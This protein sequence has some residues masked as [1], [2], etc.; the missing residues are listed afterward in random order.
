MREISNETLQVA[1][2][3]ALQVQQH[4]E[5]VR[6]TANTLRQAGRISEAQREQVELCVE[7]MQ[8][9]AQGMLDAVDAA[10]KSPKDSVEAFVLAVDHHVIANR[11]HIIANN[12]LIGH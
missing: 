8:Q 12:L 1:R 5:K 4:G 3:H 7:L 2:K 6:N 10:Y 9:S 11:Y